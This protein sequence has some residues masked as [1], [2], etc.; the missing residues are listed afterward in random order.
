M[1]KEK[2]ILK[3]NNNIYIKFVKRANMWCRTHWESGK[4]IIEWSSEKFK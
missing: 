3:E 1:S 2:K 4:Q